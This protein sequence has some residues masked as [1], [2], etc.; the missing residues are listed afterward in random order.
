MIFKDQRS[1]FEYIKLYLL[2][3]LS[4]LNDSPPKLVAEKLYVL[5]LDYVIV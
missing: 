5:Y 1:N 3:K 2:R 4:L